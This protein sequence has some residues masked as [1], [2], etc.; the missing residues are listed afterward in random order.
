MNK[1]TLTSGIILLGSISCSYGS[2]PSQGTPEVTTP[3]MTIQSFLQSLNQQVLG[4]QK[5]LEVSEDLRKWWK[6]M[7]SIGQEMLAYF[8]EQLASQDATQKWVQK[9]RQN[10]DKCS[11][12]LQGNIF[13][14]LEQIYNIL[15][16]L[17]IEQD[18]KQ[19]YDILQGLRQTCNI[20]Q[21]LNIGQDLE[22]IHNIGRGFKQISQTLAKQ[23]PAQLQNPEFQQNLEKIGQEIE[24]K[25][26]QIK[27]I[28]DQILPYFKTKTAGF[29][30]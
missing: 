16:G 21:N 27:L 2:F 18:S 10:I 9:I 29:Q 1:H 7:Q 28:L 23:I 6:E 4:I 3:E 19:I 13:Q 12:Q 11:E 30:M 5:V 26:E 17:N 8:R 25:I 14:G 24:Q 22:R 15:Q 20:L